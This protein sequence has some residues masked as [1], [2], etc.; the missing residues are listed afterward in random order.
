MCF[1]PSQ[2]LVRLDQGK[3]RQ[4][5]GFP[6]L[7]LANHPG[8]S[9]GVAGALCACLGAWQVGEHG[10]RLYVA[11]RRGLLS[12]LGSESAWQKLLEEDGTASQPACKY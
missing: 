10:A 7:P 12:G 11:A 8:S 4:K 2:L 9:A 1:E 3:W 5:A 6:S